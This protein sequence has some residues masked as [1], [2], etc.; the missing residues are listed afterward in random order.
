MLVRLPS[1]I[2]LIVLGWLIYQ[3]IIEN[4][5]NQ[6]FYFC[7]AAT[8]FCII[9]LFNR[10]F[11]IVASMVAVLFSILPTILLSIFFYYEE[12]PT[13]AATAQVSRLELAIPMALTWG[14]FLGGIYAFRKDLK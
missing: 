4:T 14:A 1:F 2:L 11:R 3:H 6:W 7:A 8:L 5:F 9:G 12:I 13:G 10:D